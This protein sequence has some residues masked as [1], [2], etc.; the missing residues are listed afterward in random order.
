MV[1]AFPWVVAGDKPGGACAP[2]TADA[3]P[4]P[5]IRLDV[6][7]VAC[8]AAV[9]G[10]DPKDAVVEAVC[11]R[12]ASRAS[13]LAS[14]GLQDRRPRGGKAEAEEAADDRVD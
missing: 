12:S 7:D 13:G 8:P 4:N 9:L 10:D 14:D 5:G 2:P 11:N 3:N 6:S 1:Q